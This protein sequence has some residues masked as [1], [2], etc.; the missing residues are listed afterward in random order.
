M[1]IPCLR[2]GTGPDPWDLFSI[3]TDKGKTK[4]QGI[5]TL[6]LPCR[7]LIVAAGMVGDLPDPRNR[8]KF[9]SR[10]TSRQVSHSGKWPQRRLKITAMGETPTWLSSSHLAPFSNIWEPDRRPVCRSLWHTHRRQTRVTVLKGRRKK[11]V[12]VLILFF[13]PSEWWG[14]ARR[15]TCH[16]CFEQN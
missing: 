11:W 2:R 1:T 4:T 16:S 15:P 5:L 8:C 13:P 9:G 12:F 7:S 10:P 3:E 6:H 14:G